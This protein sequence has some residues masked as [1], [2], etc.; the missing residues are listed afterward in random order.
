MPLWASRWKQSLNKEFEEF[1]FSLPFDKR[2]WEEDLLGT[3]AHI[4]TLKRIGIITEEEWKIIKEAII[5]LK[6]KLSID[7]NI[8]QNSEDIHT[9]MEENLT[10]IVGDIGK[11]IHAGRS[12]NDQ[13]NLDLKLYLKKESCEIA[14][15]LISFL[16]IL[17]S[18]S[19]IYIDTIMPG[20]T[21]LQHAQTVT[22]GHYFLAYYEMFQRD[23]ERLEDFYKRIDILPLGCGA[24]AGSNIPLDR[25]YTAKLLGFTKIAENSLDAVSDRDFVMEFLFFIAV[26]FLHFS[27][28]S[29][30][31]IL[32]ATQEFSFIELPESYSTGS[33]MMPHKRNPDLAEHSRGKAGRILGDLLRIMVVM[34]GL[35]LSYNGDL[36]EDKEAVFDALDQLKLTLKVWIAFLPQ[37]KF[38]KNKML[39][40]AKNSYL[41]STDIAEYLVMKGIPFRE[42]HKIVG[43]VVKYCEESK[44]RF[45]DLTLDEWQRFSPLFNNE[46]IEML[47]PEKSIYS[48]K[49]IGSP[50]PL[51]NK[52]LIEK[53]L[54]YIKEKENLWNNKK[55]SLPTLEKILNL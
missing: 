47:S 21:H 38:N 32:W 22:L 8:I 34:K 48:K 36:Q 42:A 28:L 35:P 49:T 50:N 51:L 54:N 18:L 24:L 53:K 29:E 41:F 26:T 31:I 46:V 16:K 27:R 43:E 12:R 13:V 5:E 23:L 45:E 44:K 14:E 33:S 15:L 52:M 55:N 1:S 3:S 19:E 25:E 39:N 2:L 6:N 7:I 37:L 4:L 20:Y 10:K 9:F 11:K 40:L 30:E 17:L